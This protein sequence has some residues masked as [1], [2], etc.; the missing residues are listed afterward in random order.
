MLFAK[1]DDGVDLCY[2]TTG[3]GTPIIFVHEFAGHK[4]SWEPQVRHF[5]R[6]YKS[7]PTTHAA[8]RLRLY[9]PMC[10]RIPKIALPQ[11]SWLYWII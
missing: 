10:R 2:E 1:T 4:E 11:T 5:S 8:T 9:L 6:H 7:S 3:S